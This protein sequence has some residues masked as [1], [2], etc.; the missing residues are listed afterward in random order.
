MQSMLTDEAHLESFGKDSR[1]LPMLAPARHDFSESRV[2]VSR[3]ASNSLIF[4]R[5]SADV[6]RPSVD[7]AVSAIESDT[8]HRTSAEFIC[9]GVS[10]RSS[11]TTATFEFA[12]T[13]QS[14]GNR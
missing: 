1:S 3:R 6:L 11:A 5:S 13:S 14:I 4:S 7:V 12:A 8:R 2:R 10:R 9:R